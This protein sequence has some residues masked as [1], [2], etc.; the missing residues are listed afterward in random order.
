MRNHA[1]T[2]GLL[3]FYLNVFRKGGHLFYGYT[4]DEI[5][6]HIKES[7][8]I[9][10]NI[11]YTEGSIVDDI[12]IFIDLKILGIAYMQPGREEQMRLAINPFFFF[13]YIYTLEKGS[14]LQISSETLLNRY[15]NEL[16][17]QGTRL[18][19][20]GYFKLWEIEEEIQKEIPLGH[21]NESL[22][23]ITQRKEIAN[24]QIEKNFREILEQRYPT[25]YD[26]TSKG[27][28]EN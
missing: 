22:L 6:D 25:N 10:L 18:L 20:E 27:Y 9:P 3:D 24:T 21:S 17:T 19:E 16:T 28:P 11:D 15:Y 12:N 13:N 2:G 26:D 1:I 7:A 8:L 4:L 5:V 14:V 23:D